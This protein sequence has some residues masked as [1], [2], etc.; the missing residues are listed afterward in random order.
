MLGVGGLGF[1]VAPD[2]YAPPDPTED[3]RIPP[4]RIEPRYGRYALRLAEP[5]EEIVYLGDHR[6]EGP[7]GQGA[8]GRPF[9]EIKRL[10]L[11]RDDRHGEARARLVQLTQAAVERPRVHHFQ[12]ARTPEPAES[13]ASAA[14]TLRELK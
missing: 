8:A 14:G 6:A 2:Q 7:F 1:F 9:T 3:V 5:L 12:L 10:A 4:Q 11:A 13:D